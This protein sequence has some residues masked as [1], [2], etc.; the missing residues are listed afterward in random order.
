MISAIANSEISIAF[1]GGP[2]DPNGPSLHSRF[3]V[4]GSL[5][6]LWF[7]FGPSLHTE[8]V[9]H[10]WQLVCALLQMG[11]IGQS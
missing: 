7:G 2:S 9:C 5:G 8:L 1:W 11:G 6:E 4:L 10:V 3:L